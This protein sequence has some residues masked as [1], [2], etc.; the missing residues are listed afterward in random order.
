MIGAAIKCNAEV[1]VCPDIGCGVFENDPVLVGS[2]LGEVLKDFNGYF[3]EVRLTGKPEF[4]SACTKSF[5]SKAKPKPKAKKK[6][7][8]PEPKE[9]DEQEDEKEE[10]EEQFA[11]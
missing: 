7:T 10:P 8:K 5:N 9:E 2:F 1:F 6:P 3:E 4:I 11:E